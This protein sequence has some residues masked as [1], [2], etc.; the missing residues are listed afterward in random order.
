MADCTAGQLPFVFSH[1]V[2][3]S[4]MAFSDAQTEF[5]PVV[6]AAYLEAA[7]E[8][9][10]FSFVVTPSSDPPE[11]VL[12]FSGGAITVGSARLCTGS[13]V[14]VD[15]PMTPASGATNITCSVSP[16]AVSITMQPASTPESA[17]FTP[18]MQLEA[19]GLVAGL[20]VMVAIGVRIKN[21]FWRTGGDHA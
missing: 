2:N 4:S 11:V 6:V 14:P 10:P 7:P 21:F 17:I 15:S 18:E 19:F 9:A 20:L 5:G 13:Y 1:P 12:S 16:C 3:Y 8:L